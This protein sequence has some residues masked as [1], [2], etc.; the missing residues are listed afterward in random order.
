MHSLIIIKV[1]LTE[2]K[3][4]STKKVNSIKSC[5]P[6]DMSDTYPMQ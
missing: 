1:A 5:Y 3:E 4:K 2:R 6:A